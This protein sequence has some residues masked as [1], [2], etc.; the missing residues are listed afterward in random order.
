MLASLW[1]PDPQFEEGSCTSALI[2]LMTTSI[3]IDSPITYSLGKLM[4][5][6]LDELLS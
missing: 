3:A 1:L 4:L 2:D 5:S 6:T